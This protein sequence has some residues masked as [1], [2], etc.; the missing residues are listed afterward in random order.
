MGLPP[1]L[2]RAKWMSN[3][4]A[5]QGSEK[6]RPVAEKAGQGTEKARPVAEKAR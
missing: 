5:G 2:G 3:Q 1:D 4:K 6:A